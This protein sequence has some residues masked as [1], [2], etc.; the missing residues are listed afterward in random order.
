MHRLDRYKTILS[1]L[2]K[3][4]RDMEPLTVLK[5]L[6]QKTSLAVLSKAG[7]IS[8]SR[9]SELRRAESCKG[10]DFSGAISPT[11]GDCTPI[12]LDEKDKLLI[13][14]LCHEAED[15]SSGH[16]SDEELREILSRR[17]ALS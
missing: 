12:S 5:G 4:S 15:S 1:A 10:P 14:Y 11:L 17:K 9:M 7:S 8:S 3:Q 2:K 13:K 6:V 16:E